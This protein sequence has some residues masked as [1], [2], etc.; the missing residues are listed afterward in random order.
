MGFA[1]FLLLVP[2]CLPAGDPSWMSAD[3]YDISAT[4]ADSLKLPDVNP[5]GC[6]NFDGSDGAEKC[7]GAGVGPA[8]VLVIDHAERP[9]EN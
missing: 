6:V 8:E 4:E 5:A 3:R 7:D 9:S 2:V 1:A